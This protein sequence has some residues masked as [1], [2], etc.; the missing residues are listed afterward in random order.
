MRVWWRGAGICGAV[1]IVLL[2]VVLVLPAGAKVSGANGLIAFVRS[3]SNT[4]TDATYIMNPD[5]THM[6][7]VLGGV[8]ATVPHWSPDGTLLALQT[9]V[10]SCP[11][12]SGTTI[13]NPDTNQTTVLQPPDPNLFTNCSVWSPDATHFACEMESADGTRDG[14]YTIRTS[15]GG[16]LKQ[17]TSNP[18]GSDVPI[19][20]SPD[21]K[22]IV[23][24]RDDINHNCTATSALYVVNIDGTGLHQITPGGFCDDDGSWSPNGKEIAFATTTRP[25]CFTRPPTGGCPRADSIFVVH[26]DGTGLR[27]IPLATRSRAF[28]GDVSWSPD[29]TKIAFLLS[30]PIGSPD[31]GPSSNFQEGIATANADGTDVQQ[32]TA[33][34]TPPAVPDF[35][36]DHET[37]WGPHSLITP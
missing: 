4:G 13:L 15:D 34:P 25:G 26:P 28:P 20:Y 37:D 19:D 12:C 21:G 8:E 5:G 17:I 9:S 6:H 24:G 36:F 22:Q 33:A 16:G 10:T 7:V 11:P 18:G 3:D 32:I 30:T 31:G 29:G 1:A 14:V 23:F 2:A 35:F 27:Q